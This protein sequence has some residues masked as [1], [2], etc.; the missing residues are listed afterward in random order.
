VYEPADPLM[1]PKSKI[2]PEKIYPR[3][4]KIFFLI[5]GFAGTILVYIIAPRTLLEFNLAQDIEKTTKLCGII[6]A[7]AIYN[8]QC[9]GR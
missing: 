2:S 8:L 3:P 5:M 6:D 4:N 1:M 7:G 9:D